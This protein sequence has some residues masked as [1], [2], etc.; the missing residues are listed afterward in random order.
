[1]AGEAGHIRLEKYG[2]VGYGKAGSFEGFCSGRGIAQLGRMKALEALQEG[3]TVAYC[4]SYDE[5]D[6]ITAKKIAECAYKGDEL[7][8]EVYKICAE[9]LG[10]GLSVIIDILN[11]EMI[12]IG[13]IYGRSKELL[14]PTVME[15]IEKETLSYARSVC[16][17]V[18]AE[19][20]EKIGDCAALAVAASIA[21]EKGL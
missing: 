15:V 10:M 4:E 14:E 8:K 13:S 6:E 17:I 5:L 2:P 9:H 21:E 12:V 20:G 3:K 18:P 11:P 16:R 1:M 19:L 7:S